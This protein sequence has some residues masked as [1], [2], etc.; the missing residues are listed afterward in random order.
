MRGWFHLVSATCRTRP[1][2]MQGILEKA[3]EGIRTLDPIP[4]TNRLRP[5]SYF[6]M[7]LATIEADPCVRVPPP[8]SLQE[9]WKG[10]GLSACSRGQTRSS[11]SNAG[12][13]AL[14]YQAPSRPPKTRSKRRSVNAT[15]SA[16]RSDQKAAGRRPRRP[17]ADP[18][19]L[20]GRR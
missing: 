1:A 13:V 7:S 18:N 14:R 16:R 19:C 2:P 3:A 17:T 4:F 9:G 11:S 8:A 5:A 10:R 20:F 6:E 12:A 15:A